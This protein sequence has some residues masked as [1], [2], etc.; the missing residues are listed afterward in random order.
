M[1]LRM[2]QKRTHR[3]GDQSCGCQGEGEVGGK[4][5]ETVMQSITDRMG[6]QQSPTVWHRELYSI[7]YN[8]L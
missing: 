8:N 4:D 5:W 2:K 6:K 3:H 1:N 7:S